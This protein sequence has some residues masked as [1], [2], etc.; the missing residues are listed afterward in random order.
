MIS[1]R[2]TLIRWGLAFAVPFLATLWLTPLVSKLAHKLGILDHPQHHKF[3]STVTPYLGGLAVGAGLLIVGAITASSSGELLTILVGGLA[4]MIVGLEDDRRAVAPGLKIIVEVAAGVS[5][6]MAGVRAGMFD[7]YWL[8]LGLTVLW[9]LAV[10][11]AAN[12]LDHMDGLLSGTA[13]IAALAFFAI[14]ATNGLILV[15]SLALALAGAS[16]GFLRHN[17]PPARIFL[18]DAGSLLIGFLLAAL[19]L[20]LDL[21]GESGFVRATIPILILGVPLFDTLLVIVAR[22]RERR[23]VYVGGTDHSSHRLVAAGMS[24]RDVAL[25]VY[26]VQVILS[27][28]ALLL[29]YAS[30]TIALAVAV[31]AASASVIA[32]AA[33]L[34]LA[35]G[36]SGLQIEQTTDLA[37]GS[38]P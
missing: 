20:K 35:P 21:V 33:L 10:T 22:F 7:V 11:N 32:L 23:P 14:A 28:I 13:A 38:L 25:G 4:L 24:G 37:D 34:A 6:W 30:A 8:D 12:L 15:A 9:V 5:L 1:G 31:A 29:V 16:F 2:E 26:A 17:F 19:A 3:H 27:V 18:G 36:A